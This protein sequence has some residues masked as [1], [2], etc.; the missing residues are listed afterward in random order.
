M[1]NINGV[2]VTFTILFGWL[3]L[4][5][6]ACMHPN[7]YYYDTREMLFQHTVSAFY[8]VVFTGPSAEVADIGLIS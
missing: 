7:F 4:C 1:Q 3:Q 8:G 6:A 5:L 2:I